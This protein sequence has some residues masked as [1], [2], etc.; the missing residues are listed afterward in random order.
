MIRSN[1][2]YFYDPANLSPQNS[3]ALSEEVDL[4]YQALVYNAFLNEI[5]ERDW[6]KGVVARDFFA[7]LKL[8]DASSSI[9]GKPAMD[10]IW[11]WYTGIR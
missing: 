3:R 4:N 7:P 5:M 8:T 2:S 1:N 6:I 10:V 9:N 11:Y